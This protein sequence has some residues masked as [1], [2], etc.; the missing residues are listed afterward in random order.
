MSNRNTGSEAAL[1]GSKNSVAKVPFIDTTIYTSFKIRSV[2]H[3]CP[4]KFIVLLR[5]KFTSGRIRK[6]LVAV[7]VDGSYKEKLGDS[8][9]C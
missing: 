4:E 2:C 8:S 6:A 3:F 5:I 1:I 9:S 7:I